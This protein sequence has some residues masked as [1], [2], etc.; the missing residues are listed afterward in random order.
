VLAVQPLEEDR[1]AWA[2]DGARRRDFATLAKQRYS[3]DA[4]AARMRALAAL[5]SEVQ[6][7]RAAGDTFLGRLDTARPAIAGYDL[8]AYTSML[9]A[10][11]T[12]QGNGDSVS[13]PLSVSAVIALSPHSNFSGS[14]FSARYQSITVPVLSVTG[15]DD[16]DSL[17]LV[18]SP[19]VRKAPFEYLPSRDT[20]LLW[21]VNVTHAEM[22]GVPSAGGE[23]R[24]QYAVSQQRDEGQA[25][26]KEASSRAGRRSG[27][28]AG[29][30]RSDIGESGRRSNSPTDRVMASKLIEGVTTAFLN[31]YLKGDSI[32]LEW[33]QKDEG[34]WIGDRGE[35]R[36]R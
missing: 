23:E 28:K 1:K 34:R 33:L 2:S 24:D 29:V 31:A 18:T 15:D 4:A 27:N 10:G 26:L 32:A 20:Y 30:E 35:L 9:A 7:R 25:S 19:S 5:F 3:K 6:K 11:E 13:L 16:T 8:G 22:S 12:L 14:A 36:R 17:G 21:L